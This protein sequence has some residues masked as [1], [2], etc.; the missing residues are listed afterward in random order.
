MTAEQTCAVPPFLSP[1]V[2]QVRSIEDAGSALEILTQTLEGY[3]SIFK[4]AVCADLTQIVLECCGAAD[5]ESFL[6]LTDTPDSYAGAAGLAVVVNALETGLDFQALVNTF[7]G[8]TD[9]PG[10][11]AGS[12]NYLVTV[13]AAENALEFTPPANAVE[14]GVEKMIFFGIQ[15]GTAAAVTS[16]TN[17]LGYGGVVGINGTV[18]TATVAS[19]SVR[20]GI[21]RRNIITA[22]GAGSTASMKSSG[23]TVWRGANA[24]E[25]GF[26]FVAYF[27]TAS[28]VAQQR[29][30]FGVHSGTG[31]IANVNPTTLTH[32]FGVGYDSAETVFSLIHNDGS[33]TASK[34]PLGSNFPVN[35]TDFFKLEIIAEPNASDM[36]YTF[37]NLTTGN[38]TSNSIN[39]D[40]PANTTFLNAHLWANNGTTAQAVTMEFTSFLLEMRV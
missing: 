38:V 12:A 27:G 9:T 6:D 5:P 34:V 17:Y 22:A 21:P 28:A 20:S 4:N 35:G 8:L 14:S 24:R 31:I 11:Y 7:L 13:N 33:G 16:N 1:V 18:G 2:A 23:Q 10:S 30:F 3:L 19:G 40:L 32:L 25:G 37:T 36:S 15:L 39:S 26:R 29:A